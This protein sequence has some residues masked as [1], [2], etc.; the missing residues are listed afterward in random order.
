MQNEE[1]RHNMIEC[2]IRPW[3]VVSDDVLTLLQQ[4][5]REFFVP[6]DYKELSFADIEVPL[7]HGESMM[8]PKIEAHVLQSLDIHPGERVLEVGTGSGYLTACLAWLSGDVTSIEQHADLA[9]SAAEKLAALDFEAKIITGDAFDLDEIEIFD[10][11]VVTGSLPQRTDFFEQH[12]AD[13]GRLFQVV[14]KGSSATAELVTAV[15]DNSFKRKALL[16][17]ALK[18]LTNAPEV[19]EFSF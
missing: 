8:A 4:I 1:A 16:E 19:S 17:T 5:P 15:G 14:G 18:P 7:G 13:D 11:I 2:Q 9:D 10:I 6:S 3:N 12:L